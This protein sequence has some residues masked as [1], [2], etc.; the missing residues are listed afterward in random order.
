MFSLTGGLSNR[1]NCW[2]CNDVKMPYVPGLPYC[3]C[4]MYRK[5]HIGFLV[6]QCWWLLPDGLP[7]AYRPVS[8]YSPEIF[9]N[10][11][12]SSSRRQTRHSLSHWVMGNLY[13]GKNRMNNNT[14]VE[15]LWIFKKTVWG[16]K[17]FICIGMGNRLWVRWGFVNMI[18]MDYSFC[19]QIKGFEPISTPPFISLLVQ[20]GV[21]SGRARTDVL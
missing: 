20:T 11:M 9:K 17:I 6:L 21:K 15:W 5:C 4:G 18:N 3:Q 12:M 19:L 8:P 7:P 16:L 10:E 14:S 1:Q 13:K 2:G